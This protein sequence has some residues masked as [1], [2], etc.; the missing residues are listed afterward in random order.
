MDEQIL[1]SLLKWP[2]VADCFGWL[3]LDRRG[4]WRMRNEFAQINNLSGSVIDHT[5]LSDYIARN[6][7]SDHFGQ[8]FFQNGAQRVF[9]TLDATPWIVRIHHTQEMMQMRTQCASVFEPNSALSDELGNIYIVGLVNTSTLANSIPASFIQKTEISVA[10]LHDHDLGL[11]TEGA[12]VKT[13]AC[14][15]SGSWIWRGQELAIE[16]IQS[17]E[18]GKRFRFI[19]DPKRSP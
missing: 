16:P 5:L 8:Y 10:L 12:K 4:R 18:L 3:A 2:D 14:S 13:Q 11:F 7:A 19:Q 17:I 1:Q 6:Y 9:I 15:F